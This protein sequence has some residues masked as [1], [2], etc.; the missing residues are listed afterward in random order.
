LGAFCIA[1]TL[2]KFKKTT[3]LNLFLLSVLFLLIQIP[4]NPFSD[5]TPLLNYFYIGSAIY[6]IKYAIIYVIFQYVF[7]LALDKKYSLSFY[8]LLMLVPIYSIIAPAI[9]SGLFV[10]LI[11][12]FFSKEINLKKY[13][14]YNLQLF[15]TAIYYVLFYYFQKP[16]TSSNNFDYQKL[17]ES[18]VKIGK[19]SIILVVLGLFFIITIYI[20][21]KKHKINITENKYLSKETSRNIIVFLVFMSGSIVSVFL[22]FPFINAVSHDAFQLLSNFLTPIYSL[23]FFII[24]LLIIKNKSNKI[25]VFSTLILNMYF[26]SIFTKN[27]PFSIN[28]IKLSS[29]EINI[30]LEYY[31]FI[32]KNIDKNLRFAYFRNYEDKSIMYAKPFL[33]LPDSRIAHFTNHYV[34]VGLLCYDFP[35]DKDIRYVNPKAFSFYNFVENQKKNNTFANI[36]KSTLEFLKRYKIKNLIV[37]KSSK[38]SINLDSISTKSIKNKHNYNKFYILK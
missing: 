1:E 38:L 13:L 31:N 10:V 21:C 6:H 26:V 35:K 27:Q 23:F 37:E 2:F 18:Y 9:L 24:F 4:S 22:V 28:Y 11:Y 20:I 29:D 30:D 25:I 5:S 15:F 36:E 3:I 12:L 34:P 8:F 32:K 17:I 7:L 16:T 33:F 19:I 14:I